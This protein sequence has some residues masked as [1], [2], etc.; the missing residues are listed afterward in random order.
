MPTITSIAPAFG[1]AGTLISIIG[2]GFTAESQVL[3][4]G[5][6][7]SMAARNPVIASATEIDCQV[8][9]HFYGQ[10][11]TLQVTVDDSAPA[12]FRLI[13]DPA[14]VPLTGDRLCAVEYVKALMGVTP[15]E[16]DQDSRLASLI[17]LASNQIRAYCRRDFALVA[18]ESEIC[19]GDGSDM[20]S[21][22]HTPVNSLTELSID[23]AAID[24]TEAAV[25]PEYIR[26]IAYGD[27]NPRL[28][29]NGR[30]FSCGVA[31]VSVSYLAGY[32]GVPPDIID[33]CAQQ[34]IFLANTLGRLGLT[35]DNNSVAQSS[36]SYAQ[37]TFPPPVQ[38]TLNRY[39]RPRLVVI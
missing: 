26:F 17:Q 36:N 12:D 35:T 19:D 15:E 31:N 6:S 29:T 28:R 23:G 11:D 34:V 3:F 4:T 33:A 8:P 37:I 20:L 27:Y 16:T 9:P 30:I 32:S 7:L 39:R 2:V 5:S 22:A 25:Y 18:I 1:A 13:S 38:I 21:L 14:E 24:V 10:A